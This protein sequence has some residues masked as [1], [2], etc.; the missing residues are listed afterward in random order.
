MDA[1]LTSGI[2]EANHRSG[3]FHELYRETERLLFEKLNVPDGHRLYFLSSSTEAWEII[4]QSFTRRESG[5]VFNGDFGKKWHGYAHK[6]GLTQ[7]IEFGLIEDIPLDPIKDVTDVLCFTHN[8]TSNGSVINAERLE[9]IKT[10]YP[11]KLI[12]LDAT[13]SLGG[14]EINLDH[15]DICFA[16]VQKCF[17]LPAG[18]GLM[19]CSPQAI[20]RAVENDDDLQYNSFTKL[21]D[22]RLKWETHYT[23]NVLNIALL[24]ASLQEKWT[25]K[26]RTETLKNRAQQYYELFE[27]HDKL[28]P[29]ISE[30]SYRSD[31]LICVRGSEIEI[32]TQVAKALEAGINLGSGYGK[33]K[34]DTFRI[35]NFPALS[36][37]EFKQALA[38]F[39]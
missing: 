20:A 23:P 7:S 3:R 4:A 30:K 8:E 39:G 27:K 10:E 21:N 18:L 38:F 33:W 15:V 13:S 31:T 36:D 6:L 17:G 22:N 29:L 37:D 11:E 26:E 5:H 9:K 16:S 1:I 24:H 35:A 25:L 19:I 2:A 34:K 32:S 28:S 14:V 12:A